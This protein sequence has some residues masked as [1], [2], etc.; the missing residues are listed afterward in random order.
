MTINLASRPEALAFIDS[1]RSTLS[2]NQ[3]SLE[4]NYALQL[5]GDSRQWV[6]V[7]VPSEQG[8]AA[9]LQRITV[10]GTQS[11]VRKIEYLQT[12]GDRSELTIEPIEAP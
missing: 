6:L 10:S 3:R 8:I 11:Q 4:Q 12:D 9:L 5:S 2:G 1:I 7:L